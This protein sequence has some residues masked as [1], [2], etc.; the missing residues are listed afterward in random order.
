MY[1]LAHE[2]ELTGAPLVRGLM[3]DNAGDPGALDESNKTQF[4]L[5]RDLLVA[6]VFRS[7]AASQGWRKAI[8]LPEG[9][10]FDYWDGRQVDAP[11]PGRNLDRQVDLATLPV[12][13]RAGAILPL[14]PEVLYDGQKPKDELTLDLYPH[15]ESEFQLYEDD[16]NTRQYQDGAFSQQRIRM[17]AAGH[18]AATVGDVRVQIDAVQG[19]YAGQETARRY[20]LQL[21]THA[22]PQAVTL[23]A[24]TLPRLADR[25][26]FEALAPEAEGWFYDATDRQ[27][28]LWARSRRT[29]IRQA[30]VFEVRIAADSAQTRAASFPA[31]PEMG[32]AVPADSLVVV[33]RPAEEPGHPL[34]NALG[35]K[36]E[37]WFRTT[38]DQSLHWGPHEWVLGLGE[39]RLID[40]VELAPR[41]DKNWQYGQV[42]DYEVYLGDNNGDWGAPVARGSLKLQQGPQTITFPPTAGRLLRFRVLSTQ[43]PE[44]DGAT[45]T[46]PMVS[47]AAAAQAK[48]FNASVPSDVGNVTLSEFKVL[49]HRPAAGRAQ[50]RA[51]SELAL[52]AGIAKDKPASSASEMRMNGLQFRK[53]LGM[54]PG[55][56]LNLQLQGQWQLFR[57][58]LGIDDSCR[59]AGG[60]Q[61]QVWSGTR[62]LYDSGLIQAPAVVKPELDLRGLTQ[63]SL[64]TLGARGARPGQVCGNWANAVLIGSEGD[65]AAAQR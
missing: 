62:L 8:H 32:R 46:D 54:K 52:P 45:S 20:A 55:Q 51:L 37:T 17:Q 31:A 10:W 21:H 36:P 9:L 41:T 6:P 53:G 1:T 47:A 50:Q 12:F 65:S 18:G 49:E 56:T 24:R 7:Q 26:A 23:D 35:D 16:G 61:F 64:R 19:R 3:W 30:L 22:A 40:G 38:R 58:D 57:A 11:H 33:N 25:A 59:A 5:G 14:Y 34:E 42:R 60:M 43:N 28:T 15:G 13:V 29:D 63:L 2:A 27:G 48:A 44:G 4:L 39:R